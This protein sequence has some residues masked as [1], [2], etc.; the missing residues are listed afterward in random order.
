MRGSSGSRPT[1]WR[2]VGVGFDPPRP[3]GDGG[4]GAAVALPIWIRFM[5]RALPLFPNRDFP[6]PPGILFSR[7][8]LET[9]KSLPPG[10]SDGI[11]LPFRIGTV[12]PTAPVRKK[13]GPSPPPPAA[14]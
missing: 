11:T 3:G 9:G 6:V 13:T 12:H 14:P 7:V 5:G 2:G 1:S 10:S 4:P 8:D